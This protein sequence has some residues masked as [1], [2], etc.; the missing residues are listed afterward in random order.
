MSLPEPAPCV[1][2]LQTYKVPRHQA[3]M[4][5]Y[6][7]GIGGLATPPGFFRSLDEVDP[8]QLVRHYPDVSP[9]TQRIADRHG[10]TTE[11]V[12]IT[13]G[14]DDALDRFCRS[15]LAPGRN[16]IVPTP[17]FEMLHRYIRWAG[18]EERRVDWREGAYPVDAVLDAVDASTTAI[19]VV[20]PNNPTGAVATPEDLRRMSESAPHCVLLVDLAYVEFSD[21]DLTQTV[22]G[23]PN[24][25]CFRTLSKAW[26]LAGLRVGYALG[27]AE[28]I[29][30]MRAAGNPYTV[31]GPSV[32]LACQRL[33]QGE[34]QVNEY[35]AT[36]RSHRAALTSSLRNAGVNALTSQANFVFGRSER[37]AWIRDGMAGLGIGVR[38]WPTTPA[39]QDAVRISIPGDPAVQDRLLHAI[40]AV[41]APQAILFD[42]DGVMADVSGSYRQAIVQTAATYGVTIGREDIRTA[43]AKG[44]AN[45]DWVLTQ[46]L[47]AAKGVEATL[48]DVTARFEALYQGTDGQPGLRAS[49][50]LLTS[51][52]WL[53]SL[54]DRYPLGVVTGRPRSDA[55]IFLD[56][57]G[58]GDLFGAVVCMEDGPAKP[59]PAPVHEALR[60]LNVSTAWLL[61]DTPDDVRAARAAGVVPLGVVAP[62]ED[63]ESASK[64]LTGAGAARV[65]T[66]ATELTE[67][68]P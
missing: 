25:V 46:R 50:T 43:K 30:W 15:L 61:G 53:E 29:G 48:D 64:I 67:V 37:A 19:A 11:R 23:L 20:S 66:H 31:A 7:D 18:A 13:G 44:N 38:A 49:E 42:M 24:A 68:L 9:L 39:L 56:D 40:S 12:A 54:A 35:V 32:H 41:S 3:P 10:V 22:L 16:A 4:D 65:F 60:R 14:A 28:V 63:P 45:N 5:L 62:G 52:A 26:G 55:Q 27:P 21:I 17:T 34:R 59:D 6:L 47:L 1:A 57:H 51:R 58:I 36:V 2:D 33:D 8:N